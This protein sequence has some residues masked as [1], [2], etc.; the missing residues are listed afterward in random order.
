MVALAHTPWKITPQTPPQAGIE[1]RTS[2]RRETHARLEGVRMDHSLTALRQPQLSLK[3]R[4]LSD[5]G[6]CAESQTALDRGEQITVFFPPQGA[7]RGWDAYGRVIRCEPIGF[8]YR[9]AVQFDLLP[10]A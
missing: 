4:D 8:G 3:L 5:G 10:A 1:R 9:V 6:L 7:S 2:V